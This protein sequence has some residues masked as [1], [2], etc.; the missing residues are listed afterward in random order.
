MAMMAV[1]YWLP[2]GGLMAQVQ[3]LA[4]TGPRSAVTTWTER[5]LTVL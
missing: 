3:R 1:V 2:T 5:T 4:A